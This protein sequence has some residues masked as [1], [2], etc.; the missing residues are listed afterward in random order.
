MTK[1]KIF[2]TDF[3]QDDL[4]PERKIL[5]D[6]ADVI[7]CN[8]FHENELTDTIAQADAIMLYH[9]LSLTRFTISKLQNCK[10]IVRCGVG[11]DNVDY[12]FAREKGIPVANVP[13]YGTEEIA[14]SAI[15]MI[16]ALTRGIHFLNSKLR[17]PST[18]TASEWTYKPVAP[19]Y[20]LRGRTL[21]II[22][23]G[24]IGSATALRAKAL[25]LRVV[26][27]DPYLA[28]GFDKSYGVIR[29]ESLTELLNQ[30][31]IVSVHC[32]RSPETHHLLNAQTIAL[33]PRGAYLINTARGDIVDTKAIPEAI[34]NGQLSGAAIDVLS[35]EPP[36]DNDPF[37]QAWRDVKHP[38][39]HRVIV[40][41]HSAFYS[42]EGL[43][44]MRIKGA[45]ACRNA[46]LGH[47]L[48]NIVNA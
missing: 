39:Y 42:E 19:L 18:N 15:G 32:P 38:C 26:F 30:S 10:L 48:R 25:G 24:R 27:Y 44:D 45:N 16:L 22:G 7:A 34:A 41:P 36:A 37:I 11:F 47:R 28:D 35:Q 12:R 2:I 31:D 6:L 43:Q 33:L 21:G 23:L 1:K 29:V 3:I 40:N 4:Q 8:A 46:L 14:D 20:R 17:E 13:D 5:D 9:N